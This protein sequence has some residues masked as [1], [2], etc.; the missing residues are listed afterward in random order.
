MKAPQM[1]E[2]LYFVNISDLANTI[3]PKMRENH[4][5]HDLKNEAGIQ[6]QPERNYINEG[7]DTKKKEESL[8]LYI[9]FESLNEIEDL[10]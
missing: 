4:K 6:K 3:I 2:V 9:R 5:I 7:E 8:N 10:E 1:A